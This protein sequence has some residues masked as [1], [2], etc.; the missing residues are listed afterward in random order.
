ML[1]PKRTNPSFLSSLPSPSHPQESGNVR[2]ISATSVATLPFPSASSALT[3]SAKTTSRER[4]CRRRWTAAPAAPRTTP[5]LLWH[6]STGARS[7]ANWKH[8]TPLKK[9]RSELGYKEPREGEKRGG[10]QAMNSKR[11]LGT[12]SLWHRRVRTGIGTISSERA[13]A[14]GG[15]W[16]VLFGLF[17]YP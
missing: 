5:S 4:W 17:F 13:E 9:P 15:G 12:F 8:R 1:S 10:R 7:S 2:G 16:V 11:L 14:G 3:P 6:P